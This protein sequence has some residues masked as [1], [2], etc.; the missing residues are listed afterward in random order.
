MMNAEVDLYLSKAKSWQ[1][2]IRLLRMIIL[3]RGLNEELKW[4]KPSYS[5][6]QGNVVLIQGFKGYCALLFFKGVLLKDPK[7]ILMKVGENSRFARQIR[8]N[9]VQEIMRMEKVLKDYVNQAI[10]VEKSGLKMNV[11]ESKLILPEEFQR[12]LDEIQALETAFNALT[13]GRQRAYNLYFSAP[14]QAKTR[15][16]RIE[17]YMQQILSGKGLDD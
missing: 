11:A 13:P 14:K 4:G 3:D 1:E 15:E 16:S 9:N 8:F 10:E 2:E 17:K 5:Y 7:G 6:E 12:K